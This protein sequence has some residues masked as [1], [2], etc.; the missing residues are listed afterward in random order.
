MHPAAARL[1]H[2]ALHHG[3]AGRRGS[4]S[5]LPEIEPH[6]QSLEHRRRWLQRARQSF[7]HAEQLDEVAIAEAGHRHEAAAVVLEIE[8]LG[9]DLV[10]AAR[11]GG[12]RAVVRRRQAGR[13]LDRRS[14]RLVC[15]HEAGGNDAE[16]QHDET[17]D[18]TISA[19][20][21]TLRCASLPRPREIL[22]RTSFLRRFRSPH[23]PHDR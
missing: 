7:L 6:D 18:K 4:C 11:S 21:H 3:R 20:H 2:R 10:D 17:N 5:R 14:R 13:C 15:C 19:G 22:P 16:H 12:R 8:D 23:N 9:P 1:P